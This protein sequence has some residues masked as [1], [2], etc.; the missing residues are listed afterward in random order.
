MRISCILARASGILWLV[1]CLTAAARAEISSLACSADEGTY[2][3]NIDLNRK[4]ACFNRPGYAPVCTPNHPFTIS[5]RYIMFYGGISV[6]RR[7]GRVLWPAGPPG[8][9]QGDV[10][11]D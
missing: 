8:V 6:D 4:I 2:V 9:C 7:T 10:L 11:R 5:D 1:L 3:F